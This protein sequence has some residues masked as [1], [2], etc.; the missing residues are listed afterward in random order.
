MGAFDFEVIKFNTVNRLFL[1]SIFDLFA[2]SVFKVWVAMANAFVSIHSNK[3]CWYLKNDRNHW[4]RETISSYGC[5]GLFL[6]PF[7]II[8]VS[9][10]A[11]YLPTITKQSCSTLFHDI[12]SVYFSFI[13]K[14][15]NYCVDF[16]TP[17]GMGGTGGLW[18]M[19]MG[20]MKIR[21]KIFCVAVL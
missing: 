19:L 18:W 2:I 5:C 17:D 8:K 4:I 3:R 1:K 12:R 16:V 20:E 21:N 6:S 10:L 7:H 11:V 15:Y 9:L 13:L 14:G